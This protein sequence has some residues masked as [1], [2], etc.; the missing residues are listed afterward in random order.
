MRFLATAGQHT[1][2]VDAAPEDGGTSTAMSAPQLFAAALGGL[3]AR[4]PGEL[5]SAERRSLPAIRIRGRV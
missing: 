2:S 1:V 4:V 5:V 3:R